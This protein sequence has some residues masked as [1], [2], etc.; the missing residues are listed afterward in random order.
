[1]TGSGTMTIGGDTLSLGTAD[2]FL[3]K[4]N[5]NAVSLWGRKI[6]GG[7]AAASGVAVD[8][9][10][11]AYVTGWFTAGGPLTFGASITSVTSANEDAYV[12]NVDAAGG[13]LWAVAS[14]GTASSSA[15]G[16]AIAV[17]VDD[18]IYI[19]GRF[20]GAVDFGPEALSGTTDG[21]VWQLTPPP[22]TI[23][24][25]GPGS[26][27]VQIS[28]DNLQF[29]D[30]DGNPVGP[31]IPLDN[32]NEI[33]ITGSAGADTLILD[34]ANLGSY[35]GVITFAGGAGDGLLLRGSVVHA[36][37]AGTLTVGGVSV[38]QQG[39]EHIRIDD[40]AAAYLIDGN[41]AGNQLRVFQSGPADLAY[42]FGAE[43]I[44]ILTDGLANL[45]SFTFDGEGGND[46]L[47]VDLAGGFFALPAGVSLIGG[48]QSD[49]LEIRGG[50]AGAV[51]SYT[52]ANTGSIGLDDDDGGANANLTV[53]FQTAEA[54]LLM[55]NSG[56]L[57]DVSFNLG[58]AG[59]T[60]EL[61][62]VGN[63][64]DGL[65]RL[66]GPSM[67][68]TTF[69]A[70]T[71]AL[72]IFLGGGNDVLTVSSVDT[73]YQA[74]LIIDGQGST[75]GDAVHLETDLT[76]GNLAVTAEAIHLAAVSIVT[77]NGTG[78]VDFSGGLILAG[79]AII[80]T[81]AAMVGHV[82][83]DTVDG[84]H[85]LT[86]DAAGHVTLGNLGHDIPLT[87]VSITADS[88]V[89]VNG[90]LE[91]VGAIALEADGD[92]NGV[93]VIQLQAG[94][95]IAAADLLTLRGPDLVIDGSATVQVSDIRLYTS[96]GGRSIALG[97]GLGDYQVD[98]SELARFTNLDS[99]TIGE[100]GFQSGNIS[101]T[102]ASLASNPTVIASTS[103]QV[104]LSSG[105]GTAALATGAGPI[106]LHAGILGITAQSGDD[107][108]EL[109]TSG[110]I[111]MV[112]SG[113]AIGSSMQSIDFGAGV[114]SVAITTTGVNGDVF[115]DG[116]GTL[117]L[118]TVTTSGGDV[119]LAASEI[120]FT[121]GPGS[122]SGS[123][124]L[125]LQPGTLTQAIDIGRGSEG[126]QFDLTQ[127]DLA[128]LANGFAEI[129]IGRAAGQ[130]AIT[131]GF[132]TPVQ[133]FDPIT[134]R[135]QGNGV[136]SITI[137]DLLIG[138]QGIELDAGVKPISLAADLVSFGAAIQLTGSV[139]LAGAAGS[140]Y[141]I[142]TT[143]LGDLPNGAAILI[144]GALN[145]ASSG[146]QHLTLDAG[147]TGDIS[148]I[149]NIGGVVRLGQ[150]TILQAD[151][152]NLSAVRAAALA[153]QAGTGVTTLNGLVDTNSPG[154]VVIHAAGIELGQR[155][156]TSG[157]GGVVLDAQAGP[158]ILP[159]T[160]AGF[161]IQASGPVTLAG[162]DAILLDGDI[163]AAGQ[164][165]SLLGTATLSAPVII[166]AGSIVLGGDILV[167]DG[168]GGSTFTAQSIDL[169]LT[170][171]VFD[172]GV[173]S[174]LTLAASISGI[175]G[176]DLVKTGEGELILAGT[177]INAYG[178]NT[179]VQEG[180]LRLDK[181]VA[182]PAGTHLYIGDDDAGNG[183][184][185][186]VVAAA[187]AIA[188]TAAITIHQDGT[189]DLDGHL[190]TVGPVTLLRGAAN[191]GE[192]IWNVNG[193]LSLV[194]GEMTI[195]EGGQLRLGGNVLASSHDAVTPARILGGSTLSL[196]NFSRTFDI[197]DGAA[198]ADL[199]VAVDLV[200]SG[201]AG[202]IKAGFG[203]LRFEGAGTY[204]GMTQIVAGD[205]EVDG[206]L[207]GH[208]QVGGGTLSPVALS[209]T[210]NLSLT[211]AG[212]S[213]Q[214][215]IDGA[216]Q[217]GQVVVGGAVN[218]GA[219]VATLDLGGSHLASEDDTFL[220]IDN[221]GSD[222]VSGW[223]AGLPEGTRFLFN[224]RWLRISYQGGSAGNDVVLSEGEAPGSTIT[225]PLDG[226]TYRKF[227][228]N[229]GGPIRGTASDA[230]GIDLVEV[231]IQ[232]VNTGSYWD[233]DGFDSAAPVFLTASGA[234]SWGYDLAAAKLTIGHSYEVSSRAIDQNGNVQDVMTTASFDFVAAP[235]AGLATF[236][237]GAW[238]LSVDLNGSTEIGPFS[239]Q[240]PGGFRA[241]DRPVVGDWDGDGFQTPGIFRQGEWF[242][243]NDSSGTIH[244]TISGFG[245]AGDRPIAGDWDGDGVDS[246]GF[247][248]VAGGSAT[249]NLNND[250][251]AAGDIAPFAF[252]GL[253]GETYLVG[254]WDGDGVDTPGVFRR[255]KWYFRQA[256]AA[257]PADLTVSF[258]KA[259]QQA[260]VGDWDGDGVDSIGTVRVATGQATWRLRQFA[261]RSQ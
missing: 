256:N 26:H 97:G 135:S 47:I 209:V 117:P 32:A 18:L 170:L 197:E 240:V 25:P 155:I 36:P 118:A 215:S 152:V 8:A 194:G 198:P 120:D 110:A 126:G 222:A 168:V 74:S 84:D 61:D 14:V 244:V 35:D 86:I 225:F 22:F 5:T 173:A 103:G 145:A 153:Q 132:G 261:D 255:G 236:R 211:A 109:L 17:N 185:S 176:A 165:V 76:L 119:T 34:S 148:I 134:I 92:G 137:H 183:S 175:A 59:D 182:I 48:D 223:F 83:L 63:G 54:L 205:L 204:A 212:S 21:F 100:S 24:L 210:G 202:I 129:I 58:A 2:G 77:Q 44:V 93:G 181:A 52:N 1:M 49:T 68:A 178:G 186:V 169:G 166:Q 53:G 190:D 239:L 111:S 179:L 241:G 143:H 149:G 73:S 108:P 220:L 167:N 233:G 218:L 124:I 208:V 193:L 12:L 33:L 30:A 151:D 188:D 87:A 163:A 4:F 62:D 131:I 180:V 227:S 142:D 195:G 254:D 80:D 154:G 191:L 224:E 150:L 19:G 245:Q 128:A 250:L 51:V 20:S 55:T 184:A 9:S 50:A 259:G 231:C 144:D 102:T 252:R 90:W 65:L 67:P 72:G 39:I 138:Q 27:Q 216:T 253:R 57:N 101:F 237:K 42:Q 243:S 78:T 221:L 230:S 6:S 46:T 248:H 159:E 121:G 235:P 43:P 99:L 156:V 10:G 127:T 41:A 201:G 95:I 13:L 45:N 249:W 146:Q 29:L 66:H 158:L 96:V 161:E 38:G 60:L 164:S 94:A 91:A 75:T 157:G 23:A 206:S 203:T 105:I 174:S 172:I 200:G 136:G 207:A 89:V 199:I 107:E 40:Y 3:A 189:F 171:P 11:K 242:L 187:H 28:G 160:G 162:S 247:V 69:K 141:A 228:W 257:G 147:T 260:L 112:T 16:Q 85:S 192:G 15:R 177:A 213:Y 113:G 98:D 196:G 88:D 81:T 229:A 238:K 64:S 258:G 125:T 70:P 246:I 139:A 251:D 123:G 219:G 226:D 106:T 140:S 79:N 133:F 130:H 7:E 214:V 71:A 232:D 234:E 114:A 217:Y 115:V 56:T 116:L 31:A 122:V 82:S 104:L 37:G